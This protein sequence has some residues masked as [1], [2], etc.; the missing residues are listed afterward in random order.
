MINDCAYVGETLIKY[1]PPEISAIHLKRSRGA[2]DKTFGIAWKILRAKADVYHVNYLLQDCYLA[3]KFGKRPLVGHAHG[4]DLRVGLSHRVW[5]RLVRHN[6]RHCDKILVSTPDVLGKAREY[7]EDAEYM[8]NPVDTTIFSP[9]PSEG[10][11]G[12]LR[13]LVAGA[14]D[15]KVKG[16]NIALGGLAKMKN[17]VDVSMIRYGNDFEATLGLAH[18]LGLDVKVLPKVPHDRLREYFWN[19]DVVLDHFVYGAISM[20]ALE[21]IACGRPVITYAS[22]KYAEYERFPLKDVHTEEAI[23][24]ALVGLNDELWRDEY[25]YLRENHD[26]VNAVSRI[27]QI[28]ESLT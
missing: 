1:L 17:E 15:W 22:S 9:K 24:R 14:C 2:W 16:T 26:P 3:A 28:Y 13:V 11:E 5:S 21:G 23:A 27:K 18:S 8:P 20:I 4:S 10:S 7:R 12:K 19:C 25:L 6:L